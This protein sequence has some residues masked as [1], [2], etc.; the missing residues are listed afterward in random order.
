YVVDG[1]VVAVVAGVA[2]LGAYSR[3]IIVAVYISTDAVAVVVA[4]AG[5]G[6]GCG[7]AVAVGIHYVVDG[8][9]VS[10]VA[11]VADVGGEGRAIEGRRGGEI[12]YAQ[13]RGLSRRS[14][15]GFSSSPSNAINN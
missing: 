12:F 7:C 11:G 15:E 9:V 6:G 1:G 8:G 10:V 3:V 2:G 5:A 13:L 4:D 14:T